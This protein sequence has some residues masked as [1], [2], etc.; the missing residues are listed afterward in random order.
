MSDPLVAYLNDHLSGGEVAV[1]VLEAMRD[2]ND[3]PRFENSPTRCCR[4][5]RLIMPNSVQLQRK[6][7]QAPARSNKPAV[8]FSKNSH[9]SSWG[10]PVRQTS[11]CSNP[12]NS[13]RSAHMV[14]IASGKPLRRHQGWTLGFANMTSRHYKAAPSSSTTRSRASDSVLLKPCCHLQVEHGL[15]QVT[16]QPR[17]R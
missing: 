17:D 15:R 12:W 3:D 5:F 2:Q 8:G 16:G 10:T 7:A 6:L 4:R 1:Q 14:S 9:V 13:S 11:R